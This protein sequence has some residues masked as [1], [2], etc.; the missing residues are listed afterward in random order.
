MTQPSRA[1]SNQQIA[2]VAIVVLVGFLASGIL[3]VV[4]QAI[5]N[6]L[7]GTGE[8]LDAF[9]WAQRFPELI[10]VLVAGGALGSSFI[11]VFARV[12][13]QDEAEAWRL[14]SAVMTLSALAAGVLSV[15]VV[16]L[17][18]VIVRTLL[19]P[20]AAAH[21]QALTTNLMRIM[22]VTPLIFSISGLVMGILHTY[23]M[24]L[25]PSL[26]ISMNNIGLM[27]GA[28]LIAPVLAPDP[29]AAQ[30]GNFNVYGLAYGAVLSAV[31]H[32]IVQLPALRQIR[33]HLRVL[34]D[35]R[36]PGVLNVLR[37][38]GPRV[39]GLAVVQVNFVVNAMFTSGMVSGSAS[40]L[41]NAFTLMFFALGIIG[42][43][44]G[45]AVFPS[46]SALAAANDMDGFKDR[47]S[48]ALRSVLFLAFPA[49]ITLIL[50]SE[51][52]IEAL[53]QRR[54]WTAESTQATAWALAFYATGMAGFALL[55]LLSRAFYALEDT[56]T[57]VNIGIAAMVSNIILSILFI[58]FI[59]D[60]DSLAR[61]PFA[62]LALANALTTNLEALALWWL[63]RRRIGSINDRHVLRGAGKALIA[64]GVM[65]IA[66][67]L[68][69]SFLSDQSA[70]VILI[71][72]GMVGGSVFF[73]LSVLLGLEEA[74]ASLACLMFFRRLLR[75]S[76]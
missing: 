37:L 48:S 63:L 36:V 57:P 32:L 23:Q 52:L 15:I 59:G 4:R 76:N 66:L 72:G 6:S 46:L 31:L 71:A 39:L 61:G 75:Q 34:P 1:L 51:P 69:Q 42:Q 50:L 55:E 41:T 54:E 12:R 74:R 22:M 8:A 14:A 49:M 26:A 62:G 10:F 73:A 19:A 35:W 65:G 20:G 40:A 24:F 47:L 7:F 25:L 9:V 44:L 33:S 18:P 53:F 67:W 16:L 2:R 60:R 56:W 17:A 3:G 21:V 68:M 70:L 30:V 5:I 38:M 28:L 64:S 58:Q 43:S 45:A 27:I 29:G 11:P 13:E